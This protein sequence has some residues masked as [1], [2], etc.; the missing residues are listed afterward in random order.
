MYIPYE[1]EFKSG[2]ANATYKAQRVIDN[3]TLY[4]VSY[5][6]K[7]SMAHE[8]RLYTRYHVEDYIKKGDW[9][10]TCTIRA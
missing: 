7:A 4:V 1:F 2:G 8:L 6:D 5:F 10:I 3:D 9:K